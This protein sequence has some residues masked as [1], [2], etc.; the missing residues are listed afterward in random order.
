MSYDESEAAAQSQLQSLWRSVDAKGSATAQSSG[1]GAGSWLTATHE[2]AAGMGAGP[3]FGAAGKLSQASEKARSVPFVGMYDGKKSGATRG[4][5]GPAVK[6]KSGGAVGKRGP[7]SDGKGGKSAGA[8]PRRAAASHSGA[9]NA[10]E[11][12]RAV[13]GSKTGTEAKHAAKNAA[14]AGL[15][16]NAPQGS[17]LAAAAP[18]LQAA[19]KGARPAE[20]LQKLDQPATVSGWQALAIGRDLKAM[21]GGG[22]GGGSAT[23]SKSQGVGTDQQG[24]EPYKSPFASVYL[25]GITDEASGAQSAGQRVTGHSDSVALYDGNTPGTDQKS[26]HNTSP[27]DLNSPDQKTRDAAN[28][29]NTTDMA[30]DALAVSQFARVGDAVQIGKDGKL[31]IDEAALNQPVQI[32][33]KDGEQYM[34]AMQVGSQGADAAIKSNPELAK[35]IAG[36]GDPTTDPKLAGQFISLT[37][38]SGGGQSSFFSALELAQRGY[39]NV[40]VVGYDM[41]MTPHQREVLEKLGVNV[42]NITGH[43]GSKDN[44][45]NSPVGEGIRM[46]MGGDHSYYDASIDRGG[47]ESPFS[48][49]DI[50][51]NDRATTMMRYATWL[52]SQG[53][54]QQWNDANY[55]AFL[56]SSN[57]TGNN[58]QG[59]D[60]KLHESASPIGG[61]FVDK[62]KAKDPAIYLQTPEFSGQDLLNGVSSL[63]VVG[64]WLGQK[65][66]S[67]LSGFL[68]G[69]RDTKM[70]RLDMAINP[71][72]QTQGSVNAQ[73]M[74]AQ[75]SVNMSGSSIDVLGAHL[76]AGDWAQASGGVNLSQGAGNFNVGGQNGV[77][78]DVNLSQGNLDLNVFG[79]KIDVDQG[80]SS[81]WNWLTGR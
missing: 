68:P 27:S 44:H 19:A 37:G 70:P 52:D 32:G 31:K 81:A 59:A 1:A 39:K 14:L 48:A 24:L 50:V 18:A 10:I 17:K 78:A 80:I 54:H 34:S 75:G 26:P 33:G 16:K 25:T 36:G 46:A 58:V 73:Q 67:G 21:A 53:K 42:T 35:L 61:S 65:M 7:A 5:S 45:L 9:K 6:G 57:G 23:G 38:H 12:A 79:N 3:S 69:Y 76:T 71:Q 62:T 43:S 11:A 8:A 64:D 29:S 15:G 74:A 28:A 56:K 40:S 4:K 41:A 2:A 22:S 30:Y 55:A 13:A 60:G 72:V 77:G 20:Q 47:S 51:S 63:P 49:H 66:D